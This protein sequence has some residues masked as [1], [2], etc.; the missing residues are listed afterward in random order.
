[1]ATALHVCDGNRELTIF[2]VGF[3]ALRLIFQQDVDL[4]HVQLRSDTQVA[5]NVKHYV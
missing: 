3:V 1:M 4:N 5:Y 2:P